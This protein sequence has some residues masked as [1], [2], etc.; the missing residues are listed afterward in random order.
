MTLSAYIWLTI[1]ALLGALFAFLWLKVAQ[2]KKQIA[3]HQQIAEQLKRQQAA[4]QAQ[5]SNYREK[6]KNEE[7]SRS[8]SRDDVITRLQQA[9][10]LRDE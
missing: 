9:G 3:T 5:I 8:V 7:N 6:N 4:A 10:D 1:I 2:A